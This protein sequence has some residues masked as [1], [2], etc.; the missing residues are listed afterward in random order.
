MSGIERVYWVMDDELNFVVSERDEGE[1]RQIA[2]Q[3][4]ENHEITTAVMLRV[5]VAGFPELRA[6][7]VFED[8]TGRCVWETDVYTPELVG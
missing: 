5:P 1:A 4:A 8:S 2:A 3:Y 7:A 6:I